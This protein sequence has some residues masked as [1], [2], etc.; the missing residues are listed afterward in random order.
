MS[1]RAR[2][3]TNER[4]CREWGRAWMG[5]VFGTGK[6]SCADK[7]AR[8]LYLF[9]SS[10]FPNACFP[11]K[12]CQ[13]LAKALNCGIGGREG[14]TNLDTLNGTRQS[15]GR[16]LNYRN[17]E[18][19]SFEI[20]EA[21]PRYHVAATWWGRVCLQ[22]NSAEPTPANSMVRDWRVFAISQAVLKARQFDHW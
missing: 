16:C 9:P 1:E 4:T 13:C 7:P 19:G 20:G 15:P 14:C 8:A 2:Q 5:I 22:G 11:Q 6:M 21:Q 18:V 3:R 12:S 17:P 10:F